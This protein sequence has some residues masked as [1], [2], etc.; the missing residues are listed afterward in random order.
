[1]SLISPAVYKEH[2]S[3]CVLGDDALQRIIDAN[4]AY[5]VRK[6]GPHSREGSPVQERIQGGSDL[7]TPRQ[8][9]GHIVSVTEWWAT[10]TQLLDVS[11][12]EVLHD[13]LVLH[14]L[15]T[16]QN[17]AY[18]WGPYV[19]LAYVPRHNLE[20]RI[21]ALLE[22]VGGDVT[23]GVSTGGV[24]SRTMGS[25]S[26]SY[27]TGDESRDADRNAILRRIHKTGGVVIR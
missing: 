17:A 19:D 5:M 4:E 9:V 7:L 13:G 16:G 26:E 20:E 23:A 25:W 11:D 18:H 2:D 24:A 10:W 6:I 14:R 1:V 12:Y 27:G 21:L 3:G 15:M 8:A 22:M